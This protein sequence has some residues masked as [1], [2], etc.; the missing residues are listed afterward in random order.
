MSANKHRKVLIENFLSL[1]VLEVSNMLMSFI[2]LPYVLRVLGQNGYGI[3]AMTFAFIGYF[4]TLVDYCFSVTGSRAIAISRD[5]LEEVKRIYSIIMKSKSFLLAISLFLFFLLLYS[6]PQFKANKEAYI[7]TLPMLFG[8][9]LF[10]DW[11]FQG[12]EKMKFITFINVSVK[13]I[14]TLSVFIFIKDPQDA[15]LYILLQSSGYLLAGIASQYILYKTYHIH[16]TK[17]NF[18]Q[19]LLMIKEGSTL[20]INILLPNLYGATSILLL[21]IFHQ[22]Q[23]AGVF[24]SIKKI[25]MLACSLITIMTRVFFPYLNREK[26]AFKKLARLT[27][28]V[29]FSMMVGLILGCPVIFWYLNI[30]DFSYFWV[31]VLLSFNVIGFSMNKTYGQNYL[32]THKKD[33]LY[34]K[35][36]AIAS[37]SGGL[38]A[39]PLVYFFSSLGAAA[40]IMIS[41]MISGMLCYRFHQKLKS[42]TN[43]V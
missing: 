42:I 12:L 10:T 19:S 34:L 22:E 3:Y 26:A 27:M 33:Y 32:V 35:A 1:S 4:V 37:I 39:I 24:E 9:I 43:S 8:N 29:G 13:F 36:T 23:E 40:T 25:A 6:I 14:F 5:S 21:G 17:T 15:Y 7:C 18:S 31:L 16:L 28:L 41:N 38:L 2:T 30:T 20:F 11:L